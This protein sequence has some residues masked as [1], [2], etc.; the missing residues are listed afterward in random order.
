MDIKVLPPDINY[1]RENFTVSQGAIRFGL[2]AVK[3]VGWNAVHEFIQVRQRE[4][5]FKDFWDF[6]SR[7]DTK[8][9]NRRVMESLIKAGALDKFGHRAQLLAGLETGIEHAI[10]TQ[11][12]R[13]QG[14]VSLF[15]LLPGS[16][17]DTMQLVLPEVPRLNIRD[18]LEYEKEALGLYISGHPLSELS[19][20]AEGVEA[21]RV[22]ELQ[23]LVDG[24]TVALL[25]MVSSI[26]RITSRRGEPMAFIMAE[27]LTGACEI[28]IFSDTYKRYGNLLNNKTPL[29][30]RGKLNNGGEE[31]KVLAEEILT[32]EELSP[33]V[34]LKFSEKDRPKINEI[35]QQFPGN[36]PV[37]F[38]N[39]LNGEISQVDKVL[40]VSPLPE[41]RASLAKVLGTENVKLKCSS[42][43]RLKVTTR[44]GESVREDSKVY[45]AKLVNKPEVKP[46]AT[47]TKVD[48]SHFFDPEKYILP[49]SLLDI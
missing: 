32:V 33:Q 28:V 15:D 23:E 5:I 34:W 40:W 11:R 48:K 20:L 49:Q 24:Q 12:D 19:W 7:I 6:C 27:D 14:Q 39:S 30:I 42:G 46:Q 10:R 18:Q 43:S 8:I 44:G 4:G 38:Y 22:A 36:A 29:L 2:A 13:E 25:I 45:Q 3:N 47:Q 1:S 9:T 41:L 17:Q 26:K 16:P 35:L 31:A 37:V 21:Q